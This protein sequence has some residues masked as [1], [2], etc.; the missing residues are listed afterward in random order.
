MAMITG[1]TSLVGLVGDP[2]SHSL[3]PIIHNA[4]FS[5]MGLNWCYLGIP[6]ET[7]NLEIVINGLRKVNCKGLNIT[8]PH[9]QNASNYCNEI[10]DLS[11]ELKA[12]NTLIPNK[13]NGWTGTNTD[14]EGFLAP[15]KKQDWTQKKAIILG[16]GGSARAILFGLKILRFQE[17]NVISRNIKSIKKFLLDAKINPENIQ[18][19]HIE[20]KGYTDQDPNIKKILSNSDLIINTTPI[21]MQKGLKNENGPI[22]IPLKPEDWSSINKETTLYDLIYTPRPTPWLLWGKEK[23]LKTIDGLEMLIQQGAASLKLWSGVENIP[24]E[25]MRNAAKTHLK[26]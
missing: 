2:V 20:I 24:I 15:L 11:K 6:C 19:N 9:K 17:I 16:C 23:G 22:E 1:T 14:V 21:G 8:I 5:E 4:A 13:K 25:I 18:K 26:H 3:S 12:I 7:E 10:S